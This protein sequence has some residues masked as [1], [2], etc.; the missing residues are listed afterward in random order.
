MANDLQELMDTEIMPVALPVLR[1]ACVMPALIY[2]DLDKKAQKKNGTI[3]VP[4]PQNMGEADDMNPITGSTSTDLDDSH[5]DVKLDQWKYKQFQMTDR[6]MKESLTSGILPSAA[7]DS[8]KALANSIDLCL[9]NLHRDIPYHYGTPGITPSDKASLIGVRKVLQKNLCPPG[10]R[11]LLFDVEAEAAML[12]LFSDADKT[13]STEALR[14]ASLGRLFQFE[15]YSDQMVPSHIAGS[16]QSES[17]LVNGEVLAG[18]TIMNIDGGAGTET[19]NVGD[20]FTVAGVEGQFVFKSNATA[21]SGAIAGIEFYPAAPSSFA[22]N[23][24]IT[25]VGSH[26]PNIAFRYDAFA[27]AMRPLADGT[28]SESS[29]I[30]IAVDT[31]SGI[32]LRL[33]TWRESGKATRFWRFDCL[34]GVKTLRPELAS[35]LLG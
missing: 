2:R 1:E 24:A 14:E 28:E 26:T 34:F 22:D 7:E 6:E 23:A 18:A 13:G 10:M 17:P 3:R 8:I 32:P 16:F 29:T 33:E 27:L 5:T 15:T 25:I 4:L 11:S 35:I 20:R 12:E 31:V 30:S 19:I 9:L 21:S